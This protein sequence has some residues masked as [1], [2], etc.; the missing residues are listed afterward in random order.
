MV[1]QRKKLR[2]KITIQSSEKRKQKINCYR[3]KKRKGNHMVI[4]LVSNDE[5]AGQKIK[6]EIQKTVK[7]LE[8]ILEEGI[9]FELYL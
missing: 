7:K 2:K 4:T 1:I 5:N 3:S 8:N 9:S 6:E